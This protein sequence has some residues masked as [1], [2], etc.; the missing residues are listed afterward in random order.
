MSPTLDNVDVAVGVVVT[1]RAGV[2]HGGRDG[3]STL[4]L[5]VD[6]LATVLLIGA[7][8]TRSKCN[9]VAII[10]ELLTTRAITTLSTIVSTNRL[11]PSAIAGARATAAGRRLRS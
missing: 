10:G 8:E 9:S 1:A 7:H 5:D 11:M 4:K 6:G 2:S 3:L